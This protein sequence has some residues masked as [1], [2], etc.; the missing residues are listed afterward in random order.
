VETSKEK[1][2]RK[3]GATFV[4][5]AMWIGS[6]GGISQ[7]A[8]ASSHSYASAAKPKIKNCTGKGTVRF[9]FWGDKGDLYAQ[10]QSIKAAEKACPGLHV[11]ADWHQSDYDTALKTAVGSGN[12]PDLFQLDGAKRVP[13]YASQGAL[14]PLDQFVKRDKLNLKK[15]F[16]S[17]CLGQ[18]SYKGKTYGLM[19]S[20]GNQKLLYY[21][22]DMFKA[23]G[24]KFP[25]NNWTYKDFAAAAVKLGGT[26]S[27]AS[28]S[29]SH[30]RVG[31]GW[32]GDDFAT[33]SYLYQWG[34]DWLTPN[35]KTCTLT[36]SKARTA[37][38]WWHDLRW[39]K[40][41]AATPSQANVTGD[42]FSG[43]QKGYVGMTFAGAW[44]MNYLFHQNPGATDPPVPF[45]WGVALT[46]KGPASRQSV[47]ASTA[48]VVSAHSK[49]KNA[50]YWLARFVTEGPGSAIQGANGIDTPGAKG[51]W[52]SKKVV[53]E[54]KP[55]L[56]VALAAQKYGRIPR[57]V[58]QYDK[59]WDSV[60]KALSPYWDGEN[61]NVK[62]ATNSACQNAQSTLP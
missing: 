32:N 48:E 60:S 24:V 31:Y 4:A 13:E 38:Q 54:M 47:I 40:H 19:R 10:K 50:A 58:P 53:K 18:M 43:F 35:L 57:V 5:V 21:N 41:G 2:L 45:K 17:N 15:I 29:N 34:A 55:V 39:V 8:T 44:A 56:S 16:W 52:K 30:L 3:I 7:A 49:N 61:V 14:A 42:W 11:I 28:D 36:S 9:M 46:P 27:D 20:C 51:L 6:W 37:L 33:Q 23:K 1:T 62:D 12:A 59:F 25:T 22:K 26:Y